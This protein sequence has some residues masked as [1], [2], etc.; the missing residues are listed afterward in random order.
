MWLPASYFLQ[1]WRERPSAFC[2]QICKDAAGSSGRSLNSLGTSARSV[3]CCWTVWACSQACA[4]ASAQA[5]GQHPHAHAKRVLLQSCSSCRALL[6]VS[7]AASDD[8]DD[9]DDGAGDE[10]DV[11][12]DVEGE[13]ECVDGSAESST[14]RVARSSTPLNDYDG[15]AAALYGAFW[16]HFPLHRGLGATC[17][18]RCRF[19]LLD[20]V[21]QVRR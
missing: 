3:H 21:A 15:C 14:L 10:A 1:C 19:S 6:P 4:Q 17:V 20:S 16:S 9:S 7:S 13:A 5:G 11:E 8:E 12:V 2:R 18:C